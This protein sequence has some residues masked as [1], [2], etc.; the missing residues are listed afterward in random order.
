MHKTTARSP[1][2]RPTASARGAKIPLYREFRLHRPAQLGR[3][4]QCLKVRSDPAE[5]QVP[6]CQAV[7]QPTINPPG[8]REI[9]RLLLTCH[10][11]HVIFDPD[12]NI[13]AIWW[14]VIPVLVLNQSDW[15]PENGSSAST[16]S[17]PCVFPNKPDRRPRY[18]RISSSSSVPRPQIRATS[19]RQ[20]NKPAGER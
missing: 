6:I 15:A 20:C 10:M 14:Q 13:Q 12:I 19:T 18:S 2:I 11:C 4:L 8:Q 9:A 16:R 7:A 1:P 17:V 3:K 5:M